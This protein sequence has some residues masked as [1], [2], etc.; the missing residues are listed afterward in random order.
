MI[1]IN[2]NKGITLVSLVVTIVIIIILSGTVTYNYVISNKISIYNKMVADIKLLEDKTIIYYNK[3]S[4]IPKTNRSIQINGTEYY[5]IDLS[6]LDNI[7]LNYGK[8]YNGTGNLNN[9][10]DIYLIDYNLNIYYLPGT[11]KNGEICHVK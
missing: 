2:G 1:N 6:K 11:E 10:S 8:D 7:T 3:Y 4:D 9:S 5:E